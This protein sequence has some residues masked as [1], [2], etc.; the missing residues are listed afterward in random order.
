MKMNREDFYEV[1]ESALLVF[2]DTSEEELVK[3]YGLDRSNS[4]LG[5][6][7][8][9]YLKELNYGRLKNGGC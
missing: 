7:L 8:C 3:I 5:I 6:K 2:D 4:K 1:L 9:N